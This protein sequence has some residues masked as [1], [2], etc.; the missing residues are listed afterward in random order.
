MNLRTL[1]AHLALTAIAL[2]LP[3]G[4]LTGCSTGRM[5]LSHELRAKPDANA[6][7][8][9]SSDVPTAEAVPQRHA[10]PEPSAVVAAGTRQA[11]FAQVS[12]QSDQMN[13][14]AEDEAFTPVEQDSPAP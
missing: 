14:S 5:V 6:T 12:L 9:V 1:S 2:L 10:R 4:S 7:M 13:P 8:L 11:K 3:L